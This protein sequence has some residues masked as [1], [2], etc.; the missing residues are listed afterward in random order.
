MFE[1]HFEVVSAGQ[2][3]SEKEFNLLVAQFV[4]GVCHSDLPSVPVLNGE[5]EIGRNSKR[6]RQFIKL[7]PF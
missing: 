3:L 5:V 6:G 2:E 1:T 7:N 4:V